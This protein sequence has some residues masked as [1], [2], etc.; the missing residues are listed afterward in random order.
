MQVEK[1]YAK[2]GYKPVGP[3]FDEEG[4][5]WAAW[6]PAVAIMLTG[7]AEL[8]QKMIKDIEINA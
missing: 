4:G 7:L 2:F 8:H 5:E 3:Q 1:F 6:S